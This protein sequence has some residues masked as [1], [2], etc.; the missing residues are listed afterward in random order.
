M[1]AACLLIASA[2]LGLGAFGEDCLS[3]ECLAD[4]A[5]LLQRRVAADKGA[6]QSHKTVGIV[7]LGDQHFQKVYA[8][9][10]RSMRCY[11]EKH[12]YDMHILDG[13][14]F[15]A[16]AHIKGDF[17]FRKHCTVS[18]FLESKPLN[19]S[20]AVLDGDVVVAAPIRGLDKWV[21]HGADIQLYNRCLVHEIAAGNYLVRNT[22]FARDFL[23][24][25]ANYYHKQPK[26]WSSYDNGAIQLVVMETVQVEGFKTC[27]D[28][29]H[30][31][32][33]WS[34][35]DLNPYWDYIHCTKE[36]L[37]PARAWKLNNGSLTL[38]PR[39]E[40]FVAD[41]I[42]LNSKASED[43]G[44]IMHHG[45]K[46]PDQVTDLYYQDLSQCQISKTNII[47]SAEEL[48]TAALSMAQGY[49]EYFP[50]GHRCKQCADHCMKTFS[51][52]PLDDAE[53]PRPRQIAPGQPDS[54]VLLDLPSL[55][56]HSWGWMSRQV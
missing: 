2:F 25:W 23:M 48:G 21:N 49:P 50:E 36:A 45:I 5:V 24:R 10:L 28:M 54:F 37:G 15:D 17:F 20:A 16:C 32:T 43:V 42:F 52:E 26:G 3:E 1:R 39:F 47:R 27:S 34:V 9:Q 6:R 35:D 12:G 11:A 4:H 29:Y 7:V 40:F 19:Y 51:C 31:L 13:S 56:N 41:G 44:P 18:K 14:E 8:P 53:L 46:D 33:N 22:P 55:R 38:W 30:G